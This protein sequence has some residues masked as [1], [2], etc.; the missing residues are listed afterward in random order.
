M[1]FKRRQTESLGQKLRLW[2]WPRR[3]ISRSLR[4]F[5]KRILR[6]KATPHAVAAGVAAGV[7]ASFFPLGLHFVIAAMVCWLIAGNLVAALL[8]AAVGGNPLT[9]PIL[10]GASWETGKVILHDSVASHGSPEHLS[11]MLHHMS[12]AELWRPVLEPLAV[13]AV[14]LGLVCGLVFYGITR[15]AMQVF[16]AERSKRLTARAGGGTPHFGADGNKIGSAPQ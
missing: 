16:N 2:L 8:G 14:P 10:W 3:S 4:Y 6:L 12:F 15:W 13:G 5:A 7:F 11:A 9:V 1:L